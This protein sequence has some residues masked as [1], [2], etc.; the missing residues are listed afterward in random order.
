MVTQV[1]YWALTL[2]LSLEF[3]PYCP[4]LAEVNIMSWQ[5][6]HS[7]EKRVL[8]SFTEPFMQIYV[9]CCHEELKN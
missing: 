2:S 7:L 1:L 9:L 6:T 3:Y 4:A 5:V 8:Q